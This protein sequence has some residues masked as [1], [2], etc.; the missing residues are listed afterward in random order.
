MRVEVLVRGLGSGDKEV[1][2]RMMHAADINEWKIKD[3]AV[4]DINKQ[5]KVDVGIAMGSVCGRL[6]KNHAKKLFILPTVKQLQPHEQ[7][8][9]YRQEAW[10]KLQEAKKFLEEDHVVSEPSGNWQYA[11][12][13]LPGQKKMVIYETEPPPS[14]EADILMS[15]S[16]SKLLLR[17]KEAFRAEA[18][19]I[20]EED[21]V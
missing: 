20:R 6:V 1:V 16:D 17:I 18:V 2:T 13:Y 3:I 8:S 12:V 11:T 9:K 19:V 4:E 15:K 5:E 14:V 21:N 10:S 7:N